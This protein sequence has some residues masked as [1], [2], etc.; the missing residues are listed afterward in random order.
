MTLVEGSL[1]W[2]F[3]IRK[4]FEGVL[5]ADVGNVYLRSF[6]VVW[7]SLRYT[8]GCGVRYLTL[9]GPLRL[10]FGYQLNPPDQDFFNRYQFYFSIGQAF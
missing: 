1:E 10:D 6:E 2:R 5:F 7:S 4:S 3:P 9:V 8:A